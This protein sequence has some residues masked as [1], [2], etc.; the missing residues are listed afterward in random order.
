ML[1]GGAGDSSPVPETA[2]TQ[3]S[4]EP[5]IYPYVTLI[6]HDANS[7]HKRNIRANKPAAWDEVPCA[8]VAGYAGSQFFNRK[9][10]DEVVRQSPADWSAAISL[11][12]PEGL[13]IMLAPSKLSELGN[14]QNNNNNKQNNKSISNQSRA[15]QNK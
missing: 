1:S 14:R 7:H 10:L 13:F 3:Q 6:Q 11:F 15:D 5:L 9:V 8:A 4:W 2:Q 12:S